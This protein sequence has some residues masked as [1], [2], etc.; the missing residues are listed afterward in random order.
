[1]LPVFR[2][3]KLWSIL[4]VTALSVISYGVPIEAVAPDANEESLVLLAQLPSIFRS[5]SRIR[6]QLPSRGAPDTTIGGA[7]RGIKKCRVNDEAR[8]IAIVPTTNLGLTASNSPVIFVYVPQNTAV[9]AELTLN[10]QNYEE[11]YRAALPVTQQEG[12]WMLRLPSETKLSTEKQYLWRFDLICNSDDP[13]SKDKYHAKGWLE[14]VNANPNIIEAQ[15][16]K[17]ESFSEINLLAQAGLWHDTLEKLA[18]LRLENPDDEEIQQ[19]WTELLT[20]AGLEEVAD[21][22][23]LPFVIQIAQLQVY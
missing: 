12:I 8:H 5:R 19:E 17:L 4:A 2:T 10:D 13:E 1:M 21:K 14:R 9:A 22:D 23:I 6:F 16:K 15:G 3:I 18:L 20:S 11:V 7:T